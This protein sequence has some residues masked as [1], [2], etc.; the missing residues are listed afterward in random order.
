MQQLLK[1]F[2]SEPKSVYMLSE[3]KG[4]D[5][6]HSHGDL[7]CYG[8]FLTQSIHNQ[9]AVQ[10]RPLSVRSDPKLGSNKTLKR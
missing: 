5:K 7:L 1:T 3:L 4:T 2:Y 6:E 8:I 10:R 9:L